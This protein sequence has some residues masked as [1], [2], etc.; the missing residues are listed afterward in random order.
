MVCL[1]LRR[2]RVVFRTSVSLPLA[3]LWCDWAGDGLREGKTTSNVVRGL[4]VLK[5]DLCFGPRQRIERLARFLSPSYIQRVLG[6][7]A[8]LGFR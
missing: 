3:L 1:E 7:W 5:F 8:L 4:R 6:A 2:A